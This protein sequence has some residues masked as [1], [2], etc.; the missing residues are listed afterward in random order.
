VDTVN[1][2]FIYRAQKGKSLSYVMREAGRIFF[3]SVL[4]TVYAGRYIYQRK[5]KL[6]R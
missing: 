6:K 2:V 3:Y 1:C 5:Y 4:N